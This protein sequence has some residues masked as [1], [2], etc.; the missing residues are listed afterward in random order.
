VLQ[1]PAATLE[2]RRNA[3]R[4]V[5]EQ[6]DLKSIC[7]PGHLAL[8][9]RLTGIDPVQRSRRRRSAAAQPA[10]VAAR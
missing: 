5:V 3:R 1:N 6:Y 10:M 7:L 4:F 8:I 2:M 9:Q